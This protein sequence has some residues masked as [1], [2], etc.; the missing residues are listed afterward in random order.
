MLTFLL[1]MGVGFS[2]LLFLDG[3]DS[4]KLKE[5]EKKR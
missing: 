3:R 2:L 1:L 5:K 4:K